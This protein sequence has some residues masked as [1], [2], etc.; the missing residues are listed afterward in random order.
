MMTIVRSFD[1]TSTRPVAACGAIWGAAD[2]SAPSASSRD[3][4]LA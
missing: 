1:G 3:L 2:G 4:I